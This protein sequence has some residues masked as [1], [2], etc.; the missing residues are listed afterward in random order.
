MERSMS[1]DES[2]KYLIILRNIF[3][4]KA[5]IDS[6]TILSSRW[7]STRSFADP[8]HA[9]EHPS[10]GGSVSEPETL[11]NISNGKLQ[12]KKNG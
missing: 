5:T 8:V 7:P 10:N 12:L 6:E 9:F 11:T 4:E 2:L 3:D 1:M